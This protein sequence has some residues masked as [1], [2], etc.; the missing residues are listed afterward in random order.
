MSFEYDAPDEMPKSNFL[1]APGTYHCAVSDVDEQPVNDNHMAIDGFKVS[2]EV[3]DGT[4]RHN[5]VCTETGKTVDVIF[6]NGKP[7]DKDGGKFAKQKQFAFLV[8]AGLASEADLAKRLVI[9]LPKAKGRQI[10]VTFE[11]DERNPKYLRI[12]GTKIYA[13]DDP[14][15]AAIPKDAK[16]LALIGKAPKPGAAAAS[17]AKSAN[18]NG[19]G[20]SAPKPAATPQATA[21][22]APA[23]GDWNV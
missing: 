15:V 9:D 19:N 21:A 13:V 23:S 12:A 6:F 4:V 7:T 1:E 14:R 5:N 10:V 18:G 17:P 22:A 16:A 2:L 20:A 8:A 11:A 3:L